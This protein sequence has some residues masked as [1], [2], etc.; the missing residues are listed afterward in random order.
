MQTYTKQE[1]L[2]LFSLDSLQ[3]KHQPKPNSAVYLIICK[4]AK[5]VYC[6][7]GQLDA[8]GR[9]NRLAY[10]RSRLA[11]GNHPCKAMQADY[12]LYPESFIF[13]I[14]ETCPTNEARKRE[15]LTMMKIKQLNQY[16]LYNTNNAFKF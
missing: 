12:M 8:K 9:L 13:K 2:Q 6:G 1:L 4:E 5:R 7:S 16:Q 11:K 10:H 14:L 3:P 15:Q